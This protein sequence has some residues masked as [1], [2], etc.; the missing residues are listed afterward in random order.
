[1]PTTRPTH[2]APGSEALWDWMDRRGFNQREAAEVLEIH[3]MSLNQILRGS[4]KPGLAIALRIER[5]AGI[6]AGIWLRTRVSA[7]RRRKSETPVTTDKQVGNS[8]VR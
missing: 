2:L 8:H 1:M 7:T 4:R 6:P 3:F 5:H